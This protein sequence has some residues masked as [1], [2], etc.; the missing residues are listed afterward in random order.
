MERAV[1]FA[2]TAAQQDRKLRRRGCRKGTSREL[3][4]LIGMAQAQ[5]WNL[6]DFR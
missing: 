6:V 1:V 4:Q 3:P 5:Q 2:L